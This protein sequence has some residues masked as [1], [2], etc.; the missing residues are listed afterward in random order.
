MD[1]EKLFS[2]QQ[3]QLSY[4]FERI[5]LEK[6]K[7]FI[8][9]CI[10][11][12]GVIV[13][14]GIGK[15]GLIAEKIA[16]TLVSTGTKALY[17]PAANFLHGDIG[18]FSEEDLLIVLSKSG[19]TE[20][21]LNLIP[22]LK[23]RKVPI[24]SLVSSR[25]SRLGS[26]SD[27]TLELPMEKELCPFDLTPTTSTAIQLIFGNILAVSLMQR[28]AFRLEQYALN[29]PSGSIGKK[30]TLLVQDLML[31]EDKI[32]FCAPKDR[33]ID[34]LVE[35][36]NKRCG[37]LIVADETKK[38]LGIFT[39]G[40]LRRALQIH[41]SSVLEKN[42]DALM[43]PSAIS[44]SEDILAWDAMKIMQKD[45]SGKWI[46]VMPV[47]KEEQVVGV[48]RMHDIVHAGLGG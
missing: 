40:D 45:P 22:F 26:L 35:L 37:C 15:S 7:A 24:L 14:T 43:T 32:P 9:T 20:E 21:L 42:M 13:C 18:L 11:C 27:V 10:A 1:L 31:A 41:G 4:F 28:K 47:V 16:A 44:I 48:L 36:S 3:Q 19:E 12:K 6:A 25:Q 30:A 2:Q 39:D 8:D 34:V 38:L 33:L 46:M 5:D 23:K 29:H 17:L